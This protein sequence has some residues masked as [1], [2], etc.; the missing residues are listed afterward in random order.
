[1]RHTPDSSV[2]EAPHKMRQSIEEATESVSAA[3][4][5]MEGP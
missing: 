4:I 2:V 3:Y 1:M 5:K